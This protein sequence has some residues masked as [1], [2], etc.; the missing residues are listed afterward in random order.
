MQLQTLGCKIEFIDIGGGLG[1]DYDGTRSTNASSVN[2][3][4]QEYANDVIYT[5]TQIA[6]KGSFPHPNIIAE[7]GRALTAHH[8]I[9]VFNVLET[10]SAPLW[11]EDKHA[12]AEIDPEVVR[13]HA[14][15]L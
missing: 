1:V 13:E 3:S 15:H 7:S 9:L 12:V 8:S 11:D 6:D 14:R 5:I 2:Y 10:T 4:I